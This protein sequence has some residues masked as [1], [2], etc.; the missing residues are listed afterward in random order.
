MALGDLANHR[1]SIFRHPATGKVAPWYLTVN[2]EI[3]HRHVAPS[4]STNDTELELQ[5]VL[6]GQAIGQLANFS[7]AQHIRAGR[8]VPVL[9]AHMSDHIGLHIYYGSR[10]AQPKRV[11][12]FLDLAITRLHDCPDYVLSGK[13]LL[14]ASNEWKRVRRRS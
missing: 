8:L 1:C 7:A 9:L 11:R 6:A 13:E 2:G 12:A 14:A 10:A 3:E 5:A 4:F